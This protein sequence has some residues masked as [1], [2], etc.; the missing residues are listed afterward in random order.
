MSVISIS[1][2]SSTVRNNIAEEVAKHM[3]YSLVGREVLKQ[4]SAEFDVPETK[5]SHAIHHGPSFFG[6]SELK[7]KRYI[8]YI[9][10]AGAKFLLQNDII[11]HGPA[12]HVIA[13]GVSHV[14]KVLIRSSKKDRIA[15]LMDSKNLS[16]EKAEAEVAHEEKERAK[17][18]KMAFEIDDTDS[19]LYDLTL[20]INRTGMRDA[21][22]RIADT[23]QEKRF[24]PM[25]YSLQT[26]RD[27]EC[28]YKVRALLIDLDPD[29]HVHCKKGNVV[30][31]TKAEKR[32]MKRNQDMIEERL[33][34][35]SEVEQLEIH[36]REDYFEQVALSMR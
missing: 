26:M 14:L 25:T 24:H 32:K 5:L 3:G 20:D 34:N 19:K 11:Y 30:V 18:A 16:R 33:K 31:E 21:V 36:M 28:I 2:G 27:K 9:L 6:M 29:V 8:A 17:W 22:K 1:Y 4:A 15:F 7:R 23:A 10:A 35:V 12:G 13:Q